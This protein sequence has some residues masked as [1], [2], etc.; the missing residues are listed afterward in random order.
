MQKSDYIEG[1]NKQTHPEE[2]IFW[3]EVYH[4]AEPIQKGE[5]GSGC[6]FGLI[7]PR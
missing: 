7:D 5:L 2:Q 6:L 4:Y 1:E 3:L